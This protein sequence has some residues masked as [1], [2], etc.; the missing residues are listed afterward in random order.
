[1]LSRNWRD[2]G[3]GV[4]GGSWNGSSVG[5]REGN[6]TPMGD[7]VGDDVGLYVTGVLVCGVLALGCGCLLS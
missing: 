6:R 5:G 7:C 3:V 4:D 1:M 2:Y